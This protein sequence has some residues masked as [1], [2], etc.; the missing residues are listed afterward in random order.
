MRDEFVAP[1]PFSGL[2]H[3]QRQHTANVLRALTYNKGALD[4]SDT[5]VGKTYCALVIARILGCVPLVLGP[6]GTRSGWEDASAALGVPVQFINYE[7]ARREG[8]G[9]GY[10][11]PHGQGSYWVWNSQYQMMIF[12]E[13]HLCGGKTSLTGKLLRS[14]RKAADYVLTLSATAA[15]SAEQMKNIGQTLGMFDGKGYYN[16]ILRHGVTPN[17]AGFLE[18]TPNPEEQKRAMAKIHAQIFPS[19]GARL[20]RRDI[21]GF[22]ETQI[23]TLL[24]DSDED[25]DAAS[26]PE[27]LEERVGIRQT[28][29][30]EIGEQL[31]LLVMDEIKDG[32]ASVAVF[33]N[34]TEPLNK[35]S[36]WA[37]KK[38]ISHGIIDGRQSGTKG[39][40]ERREVIRRFQSNEER[41]VLVNCAAGGAGLN[42][43]DPTGTAERVA[44]IVP[45]ESGRQMKQVCGRVHRDGGAFSRQFFVGLKGTYQEENLRRNQAK[46]RNIDTLNGDDLDAMQ[47]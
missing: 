18:W 46:I 26:E 3:W 45:S 5:G 47:F 39:D 35:F 24:L 13:A 8:H 27:S 32:R 6:K 42:L 36:A 9:F 40:A 14:S 15:D 12:D 21:P 4:A 16:W 28:L 38:K 43:H 30:I 31:K 1:E 17:Y 7:K 25:M 22:P 2:R 29:E 11:K 20:R 44:Y 37:T 19:R 41:L 10:E 23:D 34:F 33:L